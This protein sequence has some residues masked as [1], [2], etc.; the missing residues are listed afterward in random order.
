MQ[1]ETLI[2]PLQL[3]DELTALERPQFS[4]QRHSHGKGGELG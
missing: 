3:A 4:G 2:E 1:A